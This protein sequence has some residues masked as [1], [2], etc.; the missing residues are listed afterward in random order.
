MLCKLRSHR[1]Q[2]DRI[3]DTFPISTKGTLP[4]T[5]HASREHGFGCFTN[6]LFMFG[7]GELLSLEIM[8]GRGPALPLQEDRMPREV[9]EAAELAC[10]RIELDRL[11]HGSILRFAVMQ[12]VD[13]WGEKLVHT[14]K[15]RSLNPPSPVHAPPCRAW[16]LCV[17]RPSAPACHSR[18]RASCRWRIDAISR[19]SLCPR[20]TLGRTRPRRRSS[21]P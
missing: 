8:L 11:G 20:W 13:R 21:L 2:H 3:L 19:K 14:P 16:L 7:A 12:I 17:R 5:S 9:R 1:V 4:L 6:L 15:I 10:C 18:T